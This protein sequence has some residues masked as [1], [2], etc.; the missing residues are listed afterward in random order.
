MLLFFL[1]IQAFT[2]TT[3][4]ASWYGGSFHGRKT[5]SGEIFSKHKHTC[6]HRTYPFGTI[7]KVTNIKNNKSVT[8]RVNDRGPFKKGRIIDLSEAAAKHI[9]IDGVG[10][11]FIEVVRESKRT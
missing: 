1:P 7:L 4:K 5:A 10:T 8:V 6:A 3:G 11:V 9:E 2:Q